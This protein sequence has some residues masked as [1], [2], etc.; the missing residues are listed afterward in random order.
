MMSSSVILRRSFGVLG[1]FSLP[2]LNA[3][4]SIHPVAVR[5]LS[6]NDGGMPRIKRVRK[7]LEELVGAQKVWSEQ[8]QDRSDLYSQLAEKQ[9]DL[10]ERCMADSYQEAVI[11]LGEDPRCQEKYLNFYKTV[12]IGKIM[13]DLDTFAVWISYQHNRESG[14]KATPLVIVTA[15]VDRIDLHEVEIKYNRDIKMCGSV[16]WAGKTS[17][18][19]TMHLHQKQDGVNW[20]KLIGARFVMV[21]RDPDNK[22]AAFVHPLRAQ[23]TEEESIIA[24]GKKNKQLRLE[25]SEQSLLRSAPTAE[26]RE[27]IHKLFVDTLDQRS[28]S[29][30]TRTR[31]ANAVWMEDSKLKNLLICFPEQRN[32][33]NKIFG[34][35]LMRQALELAY[36]NAAVYSRRRPIFKSVDSIQF[37][38]PVE[39]GDLLYLSSQ[40]AYT[41]R[42]Y[43]QLRVHAEVVD[44]KTG[45]RDTTNVFHFT[46]KSNGPVPPVQ[47][48]TYGESML[49]LN[50]RRHFL[51]FLRENPEESVK[52]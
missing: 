37:R 10:E 12:R 46:V 25:R 51:E 44:P 35:F 41:E 14:A 6:E 26:E 21:A 27:I 29:F 31:P 50:G 28:A 20:K 43:M 36:A 22:G 40:I 7:Q 24:R 49:F 33:Y 52:S 17:M 39:V 47:P 2:I 16:T 11:P 23:T 4:T 38:K 5:W 42:N 19:V 15:L 45:E 1:R 34:G 18:E 32:L 13:E 3:T 30:S 8:Q 9:E 48:K